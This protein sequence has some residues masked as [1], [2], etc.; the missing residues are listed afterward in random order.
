MLRVNPKIH[1]CSE[2][3]A[4]AGPI[5]GERADPFQA[6]ETGQAL[7]GRR[8]DLQEDGGRGCVLCP[9]LTSKYRIFTI[10]ME[11]APGPLNKAQR[12][13][14]NSIV[15]YDYAGG[16]GGEV[17]M[18]R[19]VVCVFRIQMTDCAFQPDPALIAASPLATR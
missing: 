16:R 11:R 18:G 6:G 13:I 5:V 17:C 2:K 4:K 9:L 12:E 7:M 19:D 1:Y 8:Q 10:P 15:N 14:N 3:R